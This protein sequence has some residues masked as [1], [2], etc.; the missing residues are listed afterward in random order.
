MA[1]QQTLMSPVVESLSSHIKEEPVSR[2]EENLM[3][4]ITYTP[5]DQTQSQSS[6][7]NGEPISCFI[8]N[9]TSSD[10]STPTDPRQE[11]SSH[12]KEEPSSYDGGSLLDPRIDTTEDPAQYRPSHSNV[13]SEAKV[14][15]CPA[16]PGASTDHAQ[17]YP[18]AHVQED[19]ASGGGGPH[20]LLDDQATPLS[21][22]SHKLESNSSATINEIEVIYQHPVQSTFGDISNLTRYQRAHSRKKT[23]Q[24]P[25]CG[26][27]F[28]RKAQLVT[29]QRLH[30]GQD[31]LQCPEC[32]RTFS[33]TSQ[34]INHQKYHRWKKS[35]PCPDCGQSWPDKAQLALHQQSHTGKEPA[36]CLDCGTLFPCDSHL[37]VQERADTRGKTFTCSDCGTHVT[38]RDHLIPLPS[39]PGENLNE[40][41]QCEQHS[42]P[43]GTRQYRCSPRKRKPDTYNGESAD[44]TVPVDKTQPYPPKVEPLLQKHQPLPPGK[45]V[46]KNISEKKNVEPEENY[47]EKYFCTVQQTTDS[48]EILYHCPECSECFRSNLDLAKHQI[49]HMGGASYKCSTCGR[50][51]RKKTD[52]VIH[53]SMHG[54]SSD[55]GCPHCELSFATKS[56]LSNH[57]RSHVMKNPLPCPKC[58]K[59]FPTKRRLTRHRISHT[60]E[61]PFQCPQC[62][63]WFKRKAHLQRHQTI[64]QKG[65][66]PVTC[67]VKPHRK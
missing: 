23:P 58:G 27:Y 57:E 26:E 14:D 20:T 67:N 37:G 1:D 2:D 39:H 7:L 28:L 18:S 43:N 62:G 49:I 54:D 47:N 16:G 22:E 3:D 9:L 17:Q 53:L 66:Q 4:S 65:R 10:I 38:V 48:L 29:H 63:D 12:I 6:H 61:R 21:N 31:P 44:C 30:K 24:C 33:R 56:S 46:G 19:P 25:E 5:L 34:L 40:C 13:E 15:R 45:P 11:P 59:E 50:C 55:F 41:L 32:G 42:K 51:F 36:T 64:H 52:F 35:F 8:P 60:N